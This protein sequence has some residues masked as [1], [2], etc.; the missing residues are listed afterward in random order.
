MSLRDN[1]NKKF[2]NPAKDLPAFEKNNMSVWNCQKEFPTLPFKKMYVNCYLIPYLQVTFKALLDADLLDEI[3]TY[4][5]CWIVRPV[6]GY[7]NLLSIH[8]WGLALDFNVDQ[9]PLGWDRT[10]C[11]KM[12]LTPFTECFVKVWEDTGWIAG[13]KFKRF[14]GMH[15]ERTK[16]FG[17]NQVF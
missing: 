6:R 17:G 11:I 2:G 1:L 5:G 15:F 13:I 14:D 7:K 16:E 10:K 12:G 4:G 3:K 9:N 8:S